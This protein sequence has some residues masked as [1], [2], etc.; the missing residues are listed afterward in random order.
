MKLLIGIIV[1]LYIISNS[2]KFINSITIPPTFNQVYKENNQESQPSINNQSIQT[3]VSKI[4]EK[5]KLL[6][7]I[8]NNKP[9]YNDHVG[10]QVQV[11]PSPIP[12]T[13]QNINE[14]EKEIK[15]L[16]KSI[17][18]M[19]FYNTQK[20]KK[21]E[22]KIE[23]LT[24]RLNKFEKTNDTAITEKTSMND[25]EYFTMLEKSSKIKKKENFLDP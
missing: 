19:Q 20:I 13:P 5:R 4:E 8:T 14:N 15:S 16:L 11:A 18:D 3:L 23:Q 17:V 7:Q 9:M 6:M 22:K 24:Q 1:S 25:D 12:I 21:F 2:V 10:I